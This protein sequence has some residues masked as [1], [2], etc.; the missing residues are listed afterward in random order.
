MSGFI[1]MC[2][3]VIGGCVL[4]LKFIIILEIVRYSG[5]ISNV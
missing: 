5:L 3:V 2:V 4:L 1:V